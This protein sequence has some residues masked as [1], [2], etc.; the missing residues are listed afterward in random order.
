MRR[1][2]WWTPETIFAIGMGGV[3]AVFFSTGM[4]ARRGSQS[5]SGLVPPALLQKII[6]QEKRCQTVTDDDV[7]NHVRPHC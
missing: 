6:D 5:G 7:D 3:M 4:F 1:A 2:K